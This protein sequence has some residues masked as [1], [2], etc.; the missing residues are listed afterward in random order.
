M[1]VL[2]SVV[3]RVPML[4]LAVT[5]WF[6]PLLRCLRACNKHCCCSW[7]YAGHFVHALLEGTMV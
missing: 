3:A 1:H 4:V 7:L 5:A 2:L 6:S